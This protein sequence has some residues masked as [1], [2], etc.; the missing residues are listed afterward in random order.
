VK[1]EFVQPNFIGP[2]F[3]G[4][5]LPVEMAR[6]L[7][8]Y[9][10]LIIDLAKRLYLRE[11]PDREQPPKGFAA[12]FRLHLERI[13]QGSV[14]PVLVIP[15]TE[16]FA[17]SGVL[18]YFERARDLVAE[19]IA[20]PEGEVSA[21]FPRDLLAY[22]NQFGR[23][24]HNDESIALP[25]PGGQ[26]AVLTA[27]RRKELVLA[28]SPV[29]EREIELSGT[30]GEVDWEKSTFRLRLGNGRFAIIPMPRSFQAIAREFGGRPRHH[31]TVKGLAAYD[32]WDELQKVLSLDSLELQK[33]YEIAA[34]FEALSGLNDLW[35]DKSGA[36]PD[37]TKLLFVWE[38]MEGHYPE[39]LPLPAIVPTAEGGLLF[40]WDFAGYPSL[41]IR[42]ADLVGDFR[43]IQ[44]DRLHSECQFP[45]ANEQDWE[46][47]F[48]FLRKRIGGDGSYDF[49]RRIDPFGALEF[50][51]AY[52]N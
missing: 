14:K 2:R 29:Y 11:H 44:A 40:E 45:L 13:E 38:R 20:A 23:S 46:R 41:E 4:H 52:A 1:I 27:V 43:A 10:I 3:D 19:C 12:G 7:A 18:P 21:G 48:E 33:D 26:M 8:A 35:P 9:E 6:D 32:S 42:L 50:Q 37:R 39:E 24:L 30:I 17:F 22:F 15:A 5:T 31:V 36:A 49:P 28:A 34:R 51:R 16:A 47:F 25:G